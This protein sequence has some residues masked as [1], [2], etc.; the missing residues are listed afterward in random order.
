MLIP[1]KIRQLIPMAENPAAIAGRTLRKIPK[2]IW[3][4]MIKTALNY[5]NELGYGGLERTRQ[6]T[7][8]LF[9]H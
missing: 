3:L 5:F 8:Y 2:M 6:T 1:M 4:V 7:S 9:A